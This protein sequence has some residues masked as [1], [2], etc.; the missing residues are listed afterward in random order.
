M[1]GCGLLYKKSGFLKRKNIFKTYD[2]QQSSNSKGIE[3]WES[4]IGVRTDSNWGYSRRR[5][6]LATTLRFV[7]RSF[8][9]D[10]WSLSSIL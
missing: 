6:E 5:G 1:D 4:W 8:V 7:E 9:E 3:D 2:L 10:L